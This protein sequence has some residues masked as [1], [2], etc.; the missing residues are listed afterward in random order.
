M[1]HFQD[2]I[3][4]GLAVDGWDGLPAKKWLK[5]TSPVAPQ[6]LLQTPGWSLTWLEFFAIFNRKLRIFIHENGCFIVIY[7]SFWGL[8]SY[9]S[10]LFEVSHPPASPTHFSQATV[11][12]STNEGHSKSTRGAFTNGSAMDRAIDLG[13]SCTQPSSDLCLTYP[14]IHKVPK[15]PFSKLIGKQYFISPKNKPGASSGAW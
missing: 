4:F 10:I 9:P 14:Q 11:H 12:T 8:F 2:R 13:S 6:L 7:A 5:F 3:F 15:V 1:D